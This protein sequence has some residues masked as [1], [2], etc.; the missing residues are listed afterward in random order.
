MLGGRRSASDSGCR[1]RSSSRRKSRP[2]TPR[3]FR[4][5][6]GRSRRPPVAAGSGT[7]RWTPLDWMMRHDQQFYLPD[8]LMVK[9]DIASMANSLEVRCPLLDHEFV[10]FAATIPSAMKRDAHGG[11]RIFKRAVA[12]L[13][14]AGDLT[15]QRR[16]RRARGGVVPRASCRRLVRANLLDDRGAP[17]RSVRAVVPRGAGRRPRCRCPRLEHAALGASVSRALVSRVHRLSCRLS[18][19][20]YQ[21]PVARE[22]R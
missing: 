10:E 2:P 9:V 21:L 4:A 13:L 20:G 5:A 3:E 15:R 22:A 19:A 16:L 12:S 6:A 14:P 18:V 1:R 11:K 8:C 17:R 7:R